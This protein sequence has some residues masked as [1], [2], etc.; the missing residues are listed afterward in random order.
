MEI[1][2]GDILICAV[3]KIAGTTVFVEIE[4]SD[5]RGT[6]ILSE[7]AAGRI[8]NLRDYVVPK[9]TIVCKVLRVSKDHV[10]LSLRRVKEKEKKEI[11][12]I[13]K[14]EKGYE[15]ILKSTLKEK[16]EKVV[17]QIKENSSLK[18]FLESSKENSFELEKIVGKE[19]A[20]KILEILRKQKR[21]S[22]QIKKNIKLVSNDP[23]G[24]KMIKEVFDGEDAEIRYTSAGNYSI[25]VEEND[26]KKADQK[27]REIIERIEKK[28]KKNN[29]EFY[30]S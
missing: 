1:E 26:L 8:R 20:E 21:K 7:I 13:S 22:V 27:I 30:Y 4:G 3:E 6:I 14:V 10:E 9:K 11:L 23:H 25:K 18:D 15:G 19:N 5:K 24:L 28:A 12:E 29:F 17:N 2:I 16:S